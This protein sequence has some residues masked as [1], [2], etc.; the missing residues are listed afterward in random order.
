MTLETIIRPFQNDPSTP[1]P[2]TKPGQRGVAPVLVRV[3]TKGGTKTFNTAASF[4]A[5]LYMGKK[6]VEKSPRSEALQTGLN[7]VATS[8]AGAGT[9][10]DDKIAKAFEDT[11]EANAGRMVDTPDGRTIFMP[12]AGSGSYDSSTGVFTPN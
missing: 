9:G 3:G 1:T 2:Y 12:D 10:G 6:Q 11:Q 5:Q 7:D 8:V 4:S